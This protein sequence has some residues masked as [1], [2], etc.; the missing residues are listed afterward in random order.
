MNKIEELC[1]QIAKSIPY[2]NKDELATPHEKVFFSLRLTLLLA[3][4]E[5]SRLE[6][7]NKILR[8][9]K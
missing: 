6:K 5:I 1:M 4:D 2:Q 8:G 7:E 9:E 3:A